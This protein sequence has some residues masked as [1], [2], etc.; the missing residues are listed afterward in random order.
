MSDDITVHITEP[1]LQVVVLNS[2]VTIALKHKGQ[3]FDGA[4]VAMFL[5]VVD[6]KTIHRYFDSQRFPNATSVKKPVFGRVAEVRTIDRWKPT[7]YLQFFSALHS[8]IGRRFTERHALRYVELVSIGQF[9]FDDSYLKE[10]GYRLT[11]LRMVDA[12]R[13]QKKAD[14]VFPIKPKPYREVVKTSSS[15]EDAYE[16]QRSTNTLLM[17]SIAST[18]SSSYS[19]SSDSSSSDSGSSGSCD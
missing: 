9:S 15:S 7:P 13:R 3:T 12:M 2:E 10:L 17:S 6:P 19:S 5:G 16:T 8:T 11:V 14:A 18:S 4:R 1:G